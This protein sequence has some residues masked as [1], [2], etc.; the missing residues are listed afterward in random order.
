MKINKQQQKK[1][2]EGEAAVPLKITASKPNT[3]I[4]IKGN[5]KSSTYSKHNCK[6]FKKFII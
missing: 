6:L 4:T 3:N 5:W 1:A 2:S